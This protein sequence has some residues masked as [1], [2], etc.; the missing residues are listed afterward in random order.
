MVY[1]PR[2]PFAPLRR[3][4]GLLFGALLLPAHLSTAGAE[5]R[6]LTVWLMPAEEAGP[7]A[8]VGGAETRREIREFNDRL[9]GRHI[10][11]LNTQPPLDAQ[12]VVRNPQ[13]AVVNWSW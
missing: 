2:R 5:E 12:L 10:T 1:G 7:N 4:W 3:P 6:A 8:P 13:F 11:V 9:V